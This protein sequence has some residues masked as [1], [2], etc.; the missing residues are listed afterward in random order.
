[1]SAS[2]GRFV[3][4]QWNRPLASGLRTKKRSVGGPARVLAGPHDEG[5]DAP[6]VLRRRRSDCSSSAD[7]EMV[8]PDP[9]FGPPDS[10][11]RRDRGPVPVHVYT[12][13]APPLRNRSALRGWNYLT[14]PSRGAKRGGG[15]VA[16][17]EPRSPLRFAAERRGGR[18]DRAG[19]VALP[20]VT[21]HA[22]VD[23]GD[24]PRA[25]RVP[26]VEV[27]RCPCADPT[28]GRVLRHREVPADKPFDV[29]EEGTSSKEQNAGRSRRRGPAR[30]P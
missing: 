19:G 7:R 25:V 8:P 14:T 23:L 18:P 13:V 24:A 17:S 2:K 20:L 22:G 12:Q 29:G 3:F 28:V 16:R 21:G 9:A 10:R 1:L 15:K 30:A 5:P 11:G 26:R 4:P 27:R 6:G